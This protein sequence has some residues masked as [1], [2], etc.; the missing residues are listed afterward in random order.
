MHGD[1]DEDA[2][3]L[4]PF[5]SDAYQQ[6]EAFCQLLAERLN[7][8][9]FRTMLLRR[10]SSTMVA[11]RLTVARMLSGWEDAEN[12]EHDEDAP[13][14]FRTLTAEERALLERL[15]ETLEA[16]AEQDP[17]RAAVLRLLTDDGW[18]AEGCIVFS[19]FYDSVWWL[20]NQLSAELPDEPVGIYAG[21]NRSGV[22]RGGVFERRSRDALKDAIH[23]ARAAPAHRH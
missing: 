15:A 13:A 20:A 5:L 2:I 1:G 9:F 3:A 11:G 6:A 14:Q 23:R 18:L 8:G 22:L 16:H 4:P 21:A 17:K 12:D 10:I 19:Q 7:A